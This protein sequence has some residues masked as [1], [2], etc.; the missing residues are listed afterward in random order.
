LSWW[1]NASGSDMIVFLLWVGR[2][3]DWERLAG[4]RLR[5]IC[6]VE[7]VQIP[8]DQLT[9]KRPDIVGLPDRFLDGAHA[10]R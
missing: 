5:S 10:V 4:A 3:S 6:S 2:V 7:S 9:E 8:R 1:V